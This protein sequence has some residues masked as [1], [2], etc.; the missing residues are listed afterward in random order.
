M[1][2]DGDDDNDDKDGDDDVGDEDDDESKATIVM[3]G[4]EM[5]AVLNLDQ[6]FEATVARYY[7]YY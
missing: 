7:L 1:D 3:V 4:G 5:T 6:Q 2:G